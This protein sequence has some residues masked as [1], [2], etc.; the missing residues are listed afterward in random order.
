MAV[1]SDSA[2]NAT[3]AV[4]D[5]ITLL[6][7][8][9]LRTLDTLSAIGRRMH[10]PR[11]AEVVG[12]LGDQDAALDDA[13]QRFRAAFLP[14][15]LNSVRDQL[16][17]SADLALSACAQLRMA[18]RSRAG[19]GGGFRGLGYY[20]LAVEAL[21]PLTAILPAV[22]R[23]FVSPAQQDDDE[24]LAALQQPPLPG[25]GVQH[26]RNDPGTR[27][28]FSVYV[29]EY[30]DPST[31]VPIVMAMHGGSGHGRTF[32]WTWL[33]EA[34]SR[35]FIVV[36][37]TSTGT[38]WN[39]ANPDRDITHIEGTLELIRSR[40]A[41]DPARMLLTGISDGGTFTLLAGLIE[42]SPFTHLAPIAASFNPVLLEISDPSRLNGLPIYLIHGTLDWMFSIQVARLARNVLGSAGAS[43]TFREIRDLSHTYPTEENELII[44]WL[45]GPGTGPR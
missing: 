20:T 38:T 44:D 31:P 35:G 17:E 6:V 14:S 23:W 4:S 32:L 34:R 15:R 5:E 2:T 29:P 9:L 37:P 42:T 30:L 24:L 22:S 33:R 27:G 25:T 13:V 45:N 3:D 43:V 8:S 18:A 12:L 11:I 10:P 36:A 7:S 21:Y 1:M 40:W 26:V 19:E 39:F 28:G 16:G 41:I